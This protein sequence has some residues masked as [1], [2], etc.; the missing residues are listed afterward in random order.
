MY[1]GYII[2]SETTRN[3][4]ILFENYAILLHI[5]MNDNEF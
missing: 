2:N 3:I 5:V 1:C 4:P